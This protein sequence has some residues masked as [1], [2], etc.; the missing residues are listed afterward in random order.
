MAE[1]LPYKTVFLSVLHFVIC[2]NIKLEIIDT[3]THTIKFVFI[4]RNKVNPKRNKKKRTTE[5]EQKENIE[6]H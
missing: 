2:I 4:E 6:F 3:Y 5:E 1:T